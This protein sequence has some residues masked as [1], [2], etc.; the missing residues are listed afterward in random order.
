MAVCSGYCCRVPLACMVSSSCSNRPLIQIRKATSHQ[1]F[2]ERNT[3]IEIPISMCL[4]IINNSVPDDRGHIQQK[5]C[6]FRPSINIGMLG[7]KS[8]ENPRLKQS[9]A[10]L[11]RLI[12]KYLYMP[13]RPVLSEIQPWFPLFHRPIIDWI[14]QIAAKP[15]LE[16]CPPCSISIRLIDKK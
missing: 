7:L 4:I 13:A 12:R 11:L 14:D 5:H 1:S 2:L 3:C 16:Y 8:S 10:V 6:Y 15:A 9:T